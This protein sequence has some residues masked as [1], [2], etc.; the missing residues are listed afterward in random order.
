M[1]FTTAILAVAA[2]AAG[3]FADELEIIKL[4]EVTCNSKSAVRPPSTLG[5]TQSLT[6]P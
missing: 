5:S 1:K 3:V 6:P 2:L 4:N